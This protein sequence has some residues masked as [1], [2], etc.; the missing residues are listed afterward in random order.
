MK[1]SKKAADPT[2]KR[3]WRMFRKMERKIAAC[4]NRLDKPRRVDAAMH[5]MRTTCKRFRALLE[6]AGSGIPRRRAARLRKV[7]G[8]IKDSVAAARDASVMAGKLEGFAGVA[9]PRGAPPPSRE[10]VGALAAKLDPLL[11]PGDFAGL[12]QG[13]LLACV[14]RSA[15]RARKAFK[16]CLHEPSDDNLHAWRKRVKALHYQAATLKK[17]S[18]AKELAAACKHLSDLLGDHHD[19]SILGHHLGR[20]APR[21]LPKLERRKAALRDEALAAGAALFQ[22]SAGTTR[23]LKSP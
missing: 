13:V 14:S 2:G 21:H 9:P 3:V 1:A 23:F 5:E 18:T 7:L 19:F 17:P 15:G 22:S 8:E 11:E 6:V 20:V 16:A 10:M 4:A 12:S